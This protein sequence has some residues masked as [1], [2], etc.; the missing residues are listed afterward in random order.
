LHI[1]CSHEKLHV[2]MM[3][4][5]ETRVDE[6]LKALGLSKAEASRRVSRMIS[7]GHDHTVL[8]RVL[9]G[10]TKSPRIDTLRA[11][12]SVLE[13]DLAYLTNEVDQIGMPA[14]TLKPTIKAP[15]VP[16]VGK[17]EAGRFYPVD[18]EGQD[19][20][21]EMPAPRHHRF[22][23]ARHMAY[24]VVGDS[25]NKFGIFPGDFLICV[26]WED[27]GYTLTDGLVLV[28][29]QSRNGGHM[30]E[31]TVKQVEIRGRDFAL[32][33]RSTNPAHKEIVLRADG[34][35]DGREV[36]V[37]GLVYHVSRPINMRF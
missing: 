6:R 33:P 20:P 11:I 21:Q 12:A 5:S 35:D 34:Q 9:S 32:V 26:A 14:S 23:Q 37:V 24:E 2:A 36:Y 3:L 13:C 30:R 19:E 31:R 10:E 15:V 17:V 16:I 27:T 25:M 28:I 8:R 18:D 22:P 4:L 29:E 1:E 7:G